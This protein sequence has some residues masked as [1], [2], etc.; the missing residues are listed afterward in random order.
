[1]SWVRNAN[2]GLKITLVMATFVTL[3]VIALSLY[4]YFSMKS[5]VE[6]QASKK[7]EGVARLQSIEFEGLLR[8]IDRDL[9]LQASHPFV[10]ESLAEF[11]AAFAALEVPED[12][13]QRAY[14][15][16][17]PHPLGA[18]DRLVAA[19]SGTAYDEIHA[20][21][22]TKFDALQDAMGYYDVFL[23]NRDGDL[24]YSVFKERD[25]ATNMNSGEWRD[26]GLAD[27]F[28]QAIELGADAPSAFVDFAP[29]APSS[30][31]PAAFLAR[32]VMADGGE[33]IGVLAYQMPIDELNATVAHATG[34]GET[35][36]AF[37]VGPRGLLRTDS[38]LTEQDDVLQTRFAGPA[39][40][41]GLAGESGLAAYQTASGRKVLGYFSPIR[42]HGVNWVMIVQ[43]ESDELFARVND[44]GIAQALAG[45][46]AVTIAILVSVLFSRGLS[47]PL[48]QVTSVVER[49]AAKEYDITVPAIERQDEIGSIAR[50]LDAFRGD[51]ASAEAGAKDAA[52]KG[53]AFESTGAPMLLTDLNLQI[54]GANNAFF[55]LVNENSKDFGLG[56][57]VLDHDS[58]MGHGL[59]ELRFPPSEIRAT[60]KDHTRL[61]IKKKVSIGKSFVGLL[62]DL[63]YDKTGAEIGYVLDMKNQTFQ[64]MSE[65]VLKA[66]DGQQVRIEM[67]IDGRV[68]SVNAKACAALGLDEDRLIGKDGRALIREDGD[69]VED[70]KIWRSS[71]DGEGTGG[72]F[73]LS[74]DADH[75]IID[76]S[77]GPVPNEEGVPKGFLMIGTDVTEACV[78][79]EA[80]ERR[81]AEDAAE[82]A[83]V[84]KVLSEAL[85]RISHGDLSTEIR[86]NFADGYD[87]LR[88]DFN[89]AVGKL[90]DA[91]GEL[92]TNAGTIRSEATGINDAVLDLSKRT[93]A[94]AATLEQTTAAMSELAVSVSN[95]AKEAETAAR[96][97]DEAR[98][99]AEVSGRLVSEAADAMGRIETS[100]SEVSK[101]IGVIDDIAFQTN[102]LALNAGVEAARAGD[103]G[104]GFAVVASE[105]RALAQRCLDAS[106]EITSLIKQSG[107]SVTQGVALVGETSEALNTITESVLKISANISHI[108]EASSEQSNGLNEISTALV[109]LD[110]MTQHNANMAEKTTNGTQS[111][112]SVSNDLND[113]TGKFVIDTKAEGG[114]PPSLRAVS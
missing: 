99:H 1:M 2:I 38:P 101:I 6:E 33:T 75:R 5:A 97:A 69:A 98:G 45:L 15:D 19:D 105:V 68:V 104:R 100:S 113:T 34:L 29:Y 51:L 64:M 114:N 103:A 14:I 74:G 11:S 95:S 83:R 8:T 59:D 9:T 92:V 21:A 17:N 31:A 10:V 49:V 3:N 86:E 28:R 20:K 87:M 40:E 72:R 63:V 80:A 110:Q 79:M 55:R 41:R 48:G 60:V 7:L 107:E 94:Q 43:Q 102:L 108:A 30:G 39:L 4:G 36:S 54:V 82:Q 53:A 35:G 73:R 112:L 62:I 24:V 18:K 96:V 12:T 109:E 27:V 78:A 13:L 22:H 58:L 65:T 16:N 85:A 46:V 25:Y 56:D 66:I 26:S 90:R 37:L 61:P 52:F 106:N 77:F 70:D 71:L 23:F 44:T 93:E 67:D 42:F 89:T 57:R 91:L 76:G 111:L 84:V 81:Q 32:P 47:R 88:R 50:S